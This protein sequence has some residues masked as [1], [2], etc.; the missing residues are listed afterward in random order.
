MRKDKV[1]QRYQKITD[2]MNRYMGRLR[3]AVNHISMKKMAVCATLLFIAS[4]IPLL[5]LGKYNVMCIDDYNYG[6]AVH[7]VWMQTGSLWQSILAA[8]RQTGRFFMEW[9]GTYASCFLMAVC[10]MNFQY[11]I[12]YIVPLLMIGMFATSAFLLGKQIWVRWLGSDRP[13]AWFVMMMLLFMFY[14]V[15]EAPYEGIYWY[16]GS[17]HYI[18]MESLLFFLLT[19][20]SG[21]IWTGSKRN[22]ILWCVLASIDAVIVGGG[23][24]VTGLQAEIL[25]VFLLVY[26]YVNREKRKKAVY[27]LFPFL[28]FTAGFL[29]NILA[30]GNAVRA[31]LDTDVGYSAIT[32]VILSFYHAVVFMVEWTDAFVILLWLALL[33]VMWH[34]GKKSAKSFRH[35]VWVTIGALCIVAAMFTPTLFAVGMV[36]LSRVDNII[37]MVYYLCLFGVTQYWLG[38]SSHQEEMR[39]GLFL[40]GTGNVMTVA[41]ILLVLVVWTMTA[42]K[43]TYTGISALRSLV[44]GDAVTYYEEAM[45][46]HVQYL[47]ESITDVVI[48]PFSVRPALFDFE[49]LTEN[50][51]NWLNLAVSEYY[52]KTSVRLRGK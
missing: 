32:S 21:C 50:E 15:I 39:F 48:E 3:H 36:G 18:F 25:L 19:L 24:L 33:P 26:T 4:V 49:D 13:G 28:L 14:Q 20:V 2:D 16:N 23:N 34:I 40:E 47:D 9:Q 10:P 29:C 37:Q 11:E 17:M 35:P 46:R 8:V 52:H 7:D 6:K 5:M 44:N 51:G 43:N 27:V 41:G 42:D 31:G 22:G 45:E 38:W 30:P 1:E 12:A